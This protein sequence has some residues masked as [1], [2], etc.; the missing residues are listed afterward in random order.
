MTHETRVE[1]TRQLEKI[2]LANEGANA[3][4]LFVAGM[5][6]E[7]LAAGCFFVGSVRLLIQAEHEPW[8]YLMAGYIFILAAI[9]LIAHA[10]RLMSNRF[11][12]RRLRPLY[13][14]VLEIPGEQ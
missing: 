13:E 10:I 6:V 11:M 4:W 2:R 12:N 1:L 3:R 9:L 7:V 14:A 5:I 8:V